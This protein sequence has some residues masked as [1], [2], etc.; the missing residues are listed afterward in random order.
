MG[1]VYVHRRG[2]GQSNCLDAAERKGRSPQLRRASTKQSFQGRV[3]RNRSNGDASSL[4]LCGA[5]DYSLRAGSLR[6]G[7]SDGVVSTCGEPPD[8]K[9]TFRTDCGSEI[10]KR[11]I[12]VEF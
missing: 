4:F 10:F 2:S 7:I 3:T 1:N 12:D 11:I 9:P 6:T 8:Q 5:S